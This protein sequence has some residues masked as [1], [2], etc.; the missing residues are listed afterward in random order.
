MCT[1]DPL[2]AAVAANIDGCA[3]PAHLY[4]HR[5]GKAQ[6]AVH[7]VMVGALVDDAEDIAAI[8][9][10]VD[11]AQRSHEPHLSIHQASLRIDYLLSAMTP[12]QAALVVATT[13]ALASRSR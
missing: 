9:A 4:T 5:W 8:V 2:D 12:A 10:G 6:L 11:A 1:T 13:Q 3:D 7:T